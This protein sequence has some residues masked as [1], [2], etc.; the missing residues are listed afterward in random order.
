LPAIVLLLVLVVVWLALK[1]WR[2]D[3]PAKGGNPVVAAASPSVAPSTPAGLVA[4]QT[5]PAPS[6]A[7]PQADPVA[8]NVRVVVPSPPSAVETQRVEAV[9]SSAAPADAGLPPSPEVRRWPRFTVKGIAYGSE[10]IVMLDT[11]EMLAAG[12]RS[13]TGVRVVR[14]A[15]QCA[16]FSWQGETNSLRKGESSDKPL[17]E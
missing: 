8:T 16:W 15:Q 6:A 9:A 7:V 3:G 10:Q 11:G 5:P 1:Q 4:R 2:P 17:Q 13:K 14:V 12:D